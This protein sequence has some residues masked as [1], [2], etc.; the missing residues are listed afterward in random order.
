MKKTDITSLVVPS[1]ENMSIVTI[2]VGEFITY[3]YTSHGSVG[4]ESEFDLDKP[5]ILRL[6]KNEFHYRHPDRVKAGMCGADE[7]YGTY[8]FEAVDK[9]NAVLVFRRM[10]RG[11]VEREQHITIKVL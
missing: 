3:N 9:G 1:K 2:T 7:A 6:Q 5:N 11:T 10:F 8:Y 4:Y